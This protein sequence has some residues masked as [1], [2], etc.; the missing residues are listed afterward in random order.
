MRPKWSHFIALRA[1]THTHTHTQLWEGVIITSLTGVS[2]FS[3]SASSQAIP[4]ILLYSHQHITPF[5]SQTH[6]HFYKLYLHNYGFHIKT[7]TFITKLFMYI[8]SLFTGDT[9][10]S[11][12][13]RKCGGGTITRTEKSARITVIG[14]TPS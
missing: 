9:V 3:P 14:A 13:E 5:L 6:T 10:R 2:I 4:V 7:H 8:T 11:G 1:H 12:K